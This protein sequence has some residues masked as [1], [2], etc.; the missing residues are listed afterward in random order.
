MRVL[1]LPRVG[2]AAERARIGRAPELPSAL[3]LGPEERY[4]STCIL[5]RVLPTIE[6]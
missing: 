1:W 3:C 6:T 4:G 5:D 2:E